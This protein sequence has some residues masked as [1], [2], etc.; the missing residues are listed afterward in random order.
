MNNAVK[1]VIYKIKN[2]EAAELLTRVIDKLTEIDAIYLEYG[3]TKTSVYDFNE[4]DCYEP[5]VE[6]AKDISR[7]GS[8]CARCA[9]REVGFSM[10]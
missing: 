7:D 2:K 1:N 6:K 10:K 4:G 9:L 3:F 8:L 5:F